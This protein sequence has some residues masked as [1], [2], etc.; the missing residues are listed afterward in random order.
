[1]AITIDELQVGDDVEAWRAAGFTVDGDVCPIGSVAVRLIGAA[2][3]RGVRDWTL[4]GVSADAAAA[5]ARA[6]GIATHTSSS[7]VPDAATVHLI[8]ASRIDHVV[9]MTPHISRTTASLEALGLDV[10]GVRDA[11]MGD[12]PI[13]QV[14]FRLGEVILEVIGA[15]TGEGEGPS[16]FWGITHR[17]D[18]LDAA[19]AMLA[20][21]CGRIRDAVQPGRRIATLRTRELG[22]SV[23]TALISA[24]A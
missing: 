3:P 18:D 6:E 17:V 16:T 20:E 13:R 8:G 7:A 12:A 1:V 4:R 9:L 23:A 24:R 2:G 19:A 21:R 15:P 14:F 10:R 22:M 11:Q 5:F